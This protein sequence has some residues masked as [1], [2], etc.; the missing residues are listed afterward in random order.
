MNLGL[1]IMNFDCRNVKKKKE[2]KKKATV[3]QKKAFVN[4]VKDTEV[5]CK[6][7]SILQPG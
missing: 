5:S 4:A 7:Y 3:M 2:K 6:H 1:C